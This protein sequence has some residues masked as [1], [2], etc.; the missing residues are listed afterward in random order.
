M[1]EFI[2]HDSDWAGPGEEG[3]WGQI[4]PVEGSQEV[5]LHQ[6]PDGA[7][8][9]ITYLNYDDHILVLGTIGD[10][11]LHI[12]VYKEELGKAVYGYA[13]SAQIG[14]PDG[15]AQAWIDIGRADQTVNMREKPNRD[16]K[17]LGRYFSGVGAWLLYD[18]HVA[19]D[20]WQKV[21][22]GNEIGYI[23]DEYLNVSRSGMRQSF[24]P[25]MTEI[26]GDQIAVYRDASG[27]MKREMLIK[28][29]PFQMLGIWGGYYHVRIE[30]LYGEADTY[31]FI[32]TSDV[33][34]PASRSASTAA[35]TNRETPCYWGTVAGDLQQQRMLPKG[36][37]VTV[38]Y[39]ASACNEGESDYIYPEA[40]YLFIGAELMEGGGIEAY[41][42]IECIDYDPAL[43]YPEIMTLG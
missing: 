36:T 30:G 22:I 37:K 31:G 35:V 23:M 12:R 26:K 15:R 27:K 21:R 28:Y 10:D 38:Y 6:R 7:S 24:R 18:D 13:S 43:E 17:I 25:P 32:R 4:I 29:D 3:E 1:R 19:E 40:A 16:G 14:K 33:K 11:W 5:R 8:P 20:G 41:V 9:V 2:L 42:P 34:T 39:A